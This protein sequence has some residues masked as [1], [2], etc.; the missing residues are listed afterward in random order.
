MQPCEQRQLPAERANEC[1]VDHT[2]GPGVPGNVQCDLA[3]QL[4]SV[5]CQR[6]LQRRIGPEC[7]QHAGAPCLAHGGSHAGLFEQGANVGDASVRVESDPSSGL[8]HLDQRH[9][10]KPEHRRSQ[11]RLSQQRYLRHSG[12][13]AFTEHMGDQ[14]GREVRDVRDVSA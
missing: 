6:F 1:I 9:G 3:G 4:G 10:R 13:A 14:G 5:W 2:L 12:G 8:G 11:C 7:G